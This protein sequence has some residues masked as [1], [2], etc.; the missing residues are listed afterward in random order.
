MKI[1]DTT[2]ARATSNQL[3]QSAICRSGGSCSPFVI[4]EKH[5]DEFIMSYCAECLAEQVAGAEFLGRK[6]TIVDRPNCGR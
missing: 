2:F 5:N 6:I 3:C 1:S 4:G